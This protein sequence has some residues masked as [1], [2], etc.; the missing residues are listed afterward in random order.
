VGVDKDRVSKCPNPRAL[1]SLDGGFFKNKTKQNK[2]KTQ[3]SE[4]EN[5]TLPRVQGSGS[6]LGL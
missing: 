6:L 5:L 1:D 2:T 3:V 4:R